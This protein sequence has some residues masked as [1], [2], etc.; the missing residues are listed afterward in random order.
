[1]RRLL[2][3]GLIAVASVFVAVTLGA[4]VASGGGDGCPGNFGLYP[5][6]GVDD[7]LAYLDENGNGYL[8]NYLRKD[9]KK[10]DFI[11]DNIKLSKKT[12]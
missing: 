11:D 3:L 4:P 7:P 1:M 6:S 9:L 10:P 5:L 8:C 2:L 12:V